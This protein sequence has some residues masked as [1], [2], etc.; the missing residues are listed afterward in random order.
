M[1]KKGAWL[2][3]LCAV[4]AAFCQAALGAD[5]PKPAPPGIPG[6]GGLVQIALIVWC[7]QSRPKPIGGW[8]LLFF[9]QLY[10]GLL[11]TVVIGAASI[12]NLR[13]ST[14]EGSPLYYLFL[15]STVP[16]PLLRVAQAVVGTGLLKTRNGKWVR[17]MRGLLIADFVCALIGLGVDVAVFPANIVFSA[18]ALIWPMIWLPYF[19]VSKRVKSVFLTKDWGQTPP[20]PEAATDARGTAG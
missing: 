10:F 2:F 12:P 15:L 14:W 16:G 18:L 8:L 1:M 11:L 6:C 17:W 13:P 20:K 3:L 19:Y 4:I 5:Q 9:I 7:V